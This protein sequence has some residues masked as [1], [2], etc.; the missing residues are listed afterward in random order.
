M[1]EATVGKIVKS[2]MGHD[3]DRLYVVVGSVGGG[4]VLVADGKRRKTDNPKL[5]RARHLRVTGDSGLDIAA[6]NNSDLAKTLKK[7]NS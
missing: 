5:K 1:T 7:F 4:F 3:K 6:A 2:L